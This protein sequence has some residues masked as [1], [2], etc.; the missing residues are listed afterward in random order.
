MADRGKLEDTFHLP[1]TI[2]QPLPSSSST[3]AFVKA[4]TSVSSLL[5]YCIVKMRCLNALFVLLV[6]E[7]SFVSAQ[8]NFFENMFGGQQ[9]QQQQ[10]ANAPSDASF[11][12]SNIDRSKRKNAK[13]PYSSATESGPRANTCQ[14]IAQTICAQI[15][16]VCALRPASSQSS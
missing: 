10:Q 4:S 14:F 1:L 5:T 16:S 9:Q 6:G 13:W 2:P 11:Y 3:K 15:P 12:R 7:L 8:F